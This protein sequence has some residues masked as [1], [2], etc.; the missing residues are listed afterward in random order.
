M[1]TSHRLAE[2]LVV[3]WRLGTDS[4]R[5]PT[6]HGILDRALR[7]VHGADALPKWAV[8]ELHFTDSRVGLQ[9]VELPAILEWAQR[10]QLTTAPNPSYESAQVQISP[11]LAESMVDDLD[12]TMD[13]LKSLGGHLAKAVEEAKRELNEFELTQ[14]EEY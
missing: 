12:L 8:D 11:W 6:S 2:L 1:N 13:E 7:S 14:I 10:S 4:D 3:A 5:I 9:C